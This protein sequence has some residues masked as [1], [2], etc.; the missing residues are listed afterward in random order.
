MGPE[1]DGRSGPHAF[2]DDL[3]APQLSPD[4]H[5][6]LARSLRLRPGDPLT[7]S[8]GAGGWRRCRFGDPLE[9]HGEIVRVERRAPTLTVGF[10]LTKGQS[11][12][13][14]VVQ[15]LTELG[16]DRVVPFRAERSVTRWDGERE[17]K[18]A[19]RLARIA[20]EAAMQSRRVW[21]PEIGAATTF[22][23]LASQP[24]AVRAERGG[25][26]L[27]I[28]HTTV[29]IG[30]EGGW[31]EGERTRLDEVDLSDHVLRA[32]TAAIA[33]GVLMVRARRLAGSGP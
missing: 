18:R 22:A 26:P 28:A 6:H 14:L 29:L 7:V 13:E 19:Q 25:G 33:A 5:H 21:L 27:T 4:D 9:I 32:E 12:P 23:D 11:R 17:A 16:I 20:R 3:D 10:A 1:P 15:K 31:S 24:A 8:D 30:P 2:V